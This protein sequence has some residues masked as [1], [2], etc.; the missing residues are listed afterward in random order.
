MYIMSW[1]PGIVACF[2]DIYFDEN[3]TELVPISPRNILKAQQA[4]A[5]KAGYA[6]ANAASELEFHMFD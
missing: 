1:R 4:A 3:K 2:N 5:K 6:G